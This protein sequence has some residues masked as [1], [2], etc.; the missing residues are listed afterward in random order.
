MGKQGGQRE[1]VQVRNQV[2]S[3]QDDG[4]GRQ[5]VGGLHTLSLLK[6]SRRSSSTC[7]WRLEEGGCPLANRSAWSG[8]VPSCNPYIRLAY[9]T[10]LGALGRETPYILCKDTMV[11][12]RNN[13][14]SSKGRREILRCCLQILNLDGITNSVNMNWSELWE[15][16]EQEAWRAAATS[17][18][19]DGHYLETLSEQQQL[20]QKCY[21]QK[22]HLCMDKWRSWE[23]NGLQSQSHSLSFLVA[24]PS[25]LAD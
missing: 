22:H 21:P 4:R 8:A 19:R 9:P 24:T 12:W 14:P 11:S 25:I 3:N 18:Q 10:G 15:T 2:G 5:G 1:V 17:L 20:N 23:V 6:G 16:E 7:F 13:L